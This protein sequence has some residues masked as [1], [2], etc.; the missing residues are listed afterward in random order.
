LEPTLSLK[1][2]ANA[3]GPVGFGWQLVG[4]SFISRCAGIIAT[5]GVSIAVQFNGND[6][7]CLDGERLIALSAS[8]TP[9]VGPN[10][11]DARGLP[12]GTYTE[13]Q[14]ERHSYSR[15]RAYG[16]AD[17]V[18]A[19][20]GPAWF[21]VWT[22]GG[23]IF[24]YGVSP[25]ADA[26]THSLITASYPAGQTLHFAQQWNVTRIGDIFGNFIDFK[27]NQRDIARGTPTAYNS[28]GHEWTLAEIQ[29]GGNKIDFSYS[30]RTSAKDIS[31]S[32]RAGSK[33]L[34]VALL[35]SVT[36]YVN[37][38]NTTAIG[39]SS[40][41]VAT[42]SYVLGYT[43]SAFSGRSLLS[44]IKQCAGAATSTKCM[45][46]TTFAYTAGTSDAYTAISTGTFT[47]SNISL[48]NNEGV[49]VADFNGDGKS[50]ILI[51]CV[52]CASN[53]AIP[54]LNQLWLSNGDGTF[55]QSSAFASS[56]MASATL[57]WVQCPSLQVADFNGDGLPDLFVHYDSRCATHMTEDIIYFNNGDGTFTST[58]A[59][60]LGTHTESIVP[61]GISQTP[62]PPWTWSGPPINDYVTTSP[63]TFTLSWGAGSTFY[64]TDFNA[65]G[66]ADIVTT[67]MPAGSWVAG[68]TPTNL[69]ASTVCTHVFR[70]NGDGSFTEVPT[71]MAN[72]SLYDRFSN[73]APSGRGGVSGT[74]SVDLDG[75][76]VQ[77]L[78]ITPYS[79][80]SQGEVAGDSNK[81]PYTS[82]QYYAVE[83]IPAV[84]SRGDGNYDIINSMPTCPFL[85][86]NNLEQLFHIE[87]CNTF[88]IDYNGSGKLSWY[89]AAQ[90]NYWCCGGVQPSAT[91]S[92]MDAPAFGYHQVTQVPPPQGVTA[93]SIVADFNGDGRE[94]ILVYNPHYVPYSGCT[95]A[96]QPWST[97]YISNGDGTFTTSLTYNLGGT[98][99]DNP[100]IGDFTGSGD[101]EMISLGVFSTATCEPTRPNVLLTKGGLASAAK[102]DMLAQVISASGASQT[103][104]YQPATAANFYTPDYRTANAATGTLRDEPGTP[105]FLVNKVVYDSF[106]D[107]GSPSSPV[108]FTLENDY[109]YFGLKTDRT[110][111]GGQGYRSIIENSFGPNGSQV[112]TQTNYMQLFPYAGSIAS[113]YLYKTPYSP[114]TLPAN[115]VRSSVNIYCDE[116]AASGAAT[117]AIGTGAPCTS[118]AIIR[119][120]YL[121]YNTES[122]VDLNGTPFP[123]KAVQTSVN[124]DNMPLS[125]VSTVTLGTS[126][127]TSTVT[128]TYQPDNTFCADYQTCSWIIG[129]VSQTTEE[130]TAPN[131]IAA[132]SS[133]S[134]PN[135]TLTTGTAPIASRV[136]LTNQYGRVGNWG[137]VGYDSDSGAWVSVTNTGEFPVSITGHSVSGN[138]FWAFQGGAPGDGTCIPGTTALAIGATCTTFV[139]IGGTAV[140]GPYSTAET[141][142]YEVQ[143]L[144]TVYTAT[145]N[146]TASVATTIASPVS[147]SFGSVH[148]NTPS[149]ASITFTN[150]ASNTEP[151]SYVTAVISG[152]NASTVYSI[153]G[154]TCGTSFSNT[155]TITVQ[156]EPTT[157]G[158]GQTSNLVFTGGYDR[159]TPQDSGYTPSQTSVS[160]TIPLTGN[161]V[162]RVA[163]GVAISASTANY[164]LTPAKVSGYVAGNTDVTLVINS[165]VYVYSTSTSSPAL[166]VSGFSSGDTVTITGGGNVY[167]MGGAGALGGWGGNGNA[168]GNGGPAMSLSFPITFATGNSLTVA[169]GGGGGGG[170]GG[171]FYG[172]RTGGTGYAP[173]AGGGAGAGYNGNAGG[174]GGNNINNSGYPGG[175]TGSPS[176]SGA[177]GGSVPVGSKPT[178]G[179]GGGAGA[180]GGNGAPNTAPVS[181]L[182]DVSGG[183]GGGGGGLGAPGGSG[184]SSYV[185]GTDPYGD[186]GG[187]GGTGGSGGNA[188]T[189]NG[190]AVAGSPAKAYGSI[191]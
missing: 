70:G 51:T 96:A 12:A 158:A 182:Y 71:N 133:G 110:G 185:A 72:Y 91:L 170:G 69:C 15:I 153:T 112:A 114:P 47:F 127:Y 36:T 187:V 34:S 44:S 178:G 57:S 126:T 63:Y 37:S 67:S 123:T 89:Q 25:T 117:E 26:N 141:I 55:T 77:D 174:L 65:D 130:R 30:D 46:A 131:A 122:A 172:L 45:P 100:I 28:T 186:G 97:L 20:S 16:Y 78:F 99:L 108:P 8:G 68:T 4:I 175:S 56:A 115:P 134:G 139:G 188:V 64:I 150:G 146:F 132:T 128:N 61:S 74:R 5:D 164:A 10:Q 73:P 190:N 79:L 181:S 80:A 176:T 27:Y 120:P 156:Y 52:G 152:G 105:V 142:S 24:D 41:A 23:Q 104:G 6:K 54:V 149:A 33:N 155:C 191:L 3:K 35:Q 184:G 81:Y 86:N 124:A 111:R 129:R 140:G 183:A 137:T 171:A 138:N 49:F 189:K 2:R 83:S 98:I 116:T 84:R 159:R 88:P 43:V 95:V 75:D 168:G 58:V 113:S 154:N 87:T 173:G 165:G 166:T 93:A 19:A 179:A 42:T 92:V 94:D 161:A 148:V 85:P 66:I 76:G 107:R 157:V 48:A 18:N 102:P 136:T 145:Q 21:R 17:G 162:S 106:T 118:T 167:G 163:S 121:L 125:I 11:G 101:I 180:A 38:P 14:T 39:P 135:A 31:E 59:T 22:K 177:A 60:G 9:L 160:I 103:I 151:L 90:R 50:D 147:V 13:Y 53:G 143:G 32:Y 7:L 109:W 62:N 29:Y 144:T 40:N 169:G 82:N 1:Y 119:Q